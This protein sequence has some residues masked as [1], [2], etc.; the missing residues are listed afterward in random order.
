[1]DRGHEQIFFVPLATQHG[2]LCKDM[3]AITATVDNEWSK[4]KHNHTSTFHTVCQTELSRRYKNWSENMC[5][6][7]WWKMFNLSN[8]S[9]KT[10]LVIFISII[11]PPCRIIQNEHSR[12]FTYAVRW[13]KHGV[14]VQPLHLI[15]STKS[16]GLRTRWSHDPARER[17]PRLP[18]FENAGPKRRPEDT[19][20]PARLTL[21]TAA[22]LLATLTVWLEFARSQ[23]LNTTGLVFDFSSSML[24]QLSYSEPFN[25]YVVNH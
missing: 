21:F 11:F 12:D 23:F 24:Y 5:V 10:E 19:R 8:C 13:Q 22:A 15:S 7:L 9:G 20:F 16:A 4:D 3:L 17:G 1:M 25:R 2:E 14:S 18:V 6:Q